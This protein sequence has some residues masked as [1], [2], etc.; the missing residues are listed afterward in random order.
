MAA[1]HRA[2]SKLVLHF[3]VNRTLIMLDPAGGKSMEYMLNAIVADGAWGEVTVDGE[4]APT[5]HVCMELP[6]ELTGRPVTTYHDWVQE[7]WQGSANRPVRN[8][9][10]RAGAAASPTRSQAGESET[11]EHFHGA[12]Q[13]RRAVSSAV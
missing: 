1:P 13:R 6:A 3:D 5:P 7:R 8:A 4:W 12:R 11:V 2:A 10:A 9:C